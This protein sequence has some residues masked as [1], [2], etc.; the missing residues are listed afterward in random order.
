MPYREKTAWLSLL[1]MVVAFGPY[2]L[3]AAA[4]SH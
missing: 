1:A 4:H 2:F 3:I